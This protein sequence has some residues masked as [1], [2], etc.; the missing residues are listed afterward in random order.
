ME[1]FIPTPDGLTLWTETFGDPG[2]PAVLLVMGAM[3]QGIFW[4]DG[5]CQRLAEAGFFV[6]RYDHRDTGRSSKVGWWRPY[7]LTGLTQDALAVLQGLG[8]AKATVVGLS[9]GG[10]IGQL[11]AAWHPQRVERL[12]LI[13][14][15]ADH[16]PLMA[17]SMGLPLGRWRLPP[18]EPEYL[19][20]LK[21]LK[22]HPPQGPEAW[23]A[24]ASQ[25]WAVTYAGSRPFP[26]EAVEDAIARAHARTD[27]P[28]A[29]MHHSLAVAA[30][31]H[32][33]ALVQTIRVPTLVVHGR[34]DPLLPLAHG[35][36]L[37]QHIPAAQSLTLDMGH[38]FMWSWDDE[39]RAAIEGFAV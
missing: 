25:G 14:T 16:R 3:N 27:K 36:Y 5:F 6:I 4:P 31:R 21:R 38:S 39:V 8:V 10:F 23:A 12:V 22:Q 34:W 20:C 30:S 37:A 11:L 17:A 32:R 28:L 35:Q 2:R 19:A 13:S 1:T 33:L 18:P 15:S 29:A 9:M 24:S 7:T 26:R